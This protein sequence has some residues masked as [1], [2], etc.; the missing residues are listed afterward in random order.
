VHTSKQKRARSG[1]VPSPA[2][3]IPGHGGYVYFSAPRLVFGNQSYRRA[4]DAVRTHWPH[5]QIV[6][7]R[8]TFVNVADWRR[9]WPLLLS[10]IRVLVFA[11]DSAWY[12]GRGVW[13]EINEA[14][15]AGVPVLLVDAVTGRLHGLADCDFSAADPDDWNQHVHVTLRSP[16]ER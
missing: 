5:A 13:R 6:E 10:S 15:S 12:I 1:R 16:T 14:E 4:L 3:R 11:T 9:R 7:S 2:H 8:H